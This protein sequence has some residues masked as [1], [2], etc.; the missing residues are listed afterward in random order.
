MSA[1][2]S[3]ANIHHAGVHLSCAKQSL[4]IALEGVNQAANILHEE[5]KW[6]DETT[7]SGR[8]V[9]AAAKATEK[10]RQEF[11]KALI[12]AP[13]VAP[14]LY[15]S[16]PFKKTEPRQNNNVVAFDAHASKA[17]EAN[18]SKAVK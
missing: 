7:E 17:C 8:A 18:L 16:R 11:M 6:A 4:D 1:E 2:V 9:I 13:D 12:E 15:F 10:F 5:A 14:I 3:M